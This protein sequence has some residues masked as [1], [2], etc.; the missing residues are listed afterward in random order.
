MQKFRLPLCYTAT[1]NSPG[2]DIKRPVKYL[3]S[4]SFLVGKAYLRK[5]KKNRYLNSIL[6]ITFWNQKLF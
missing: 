6:F 2:D 3:F 1:C 4:S 5:A